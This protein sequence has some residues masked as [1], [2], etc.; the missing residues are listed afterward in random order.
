[1]SFSARVKQELEG[2]QK[3]K[4]GR[5]AFLRRAFLDTGSMSDPEKGYHLEFVCS[6][7]EEADLIVSALAAYEIRAK[8]VPRKKYQVVYIKESEDISTLLNVIGAHVS[9]MELENMRILKGVRNSVNRKVNCEAANITKAVNAA[10]KQVEDIEYI[11][12]H[13]GFDSLPDH[14]RQMAELRLEYPDAT[15][16]ELGEYLT[17]AVGK[18]GVNHRLRKLGE[19]AEKLKNGGFL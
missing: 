17:P 18:S 4:G 5:R 10:A 12:G 13:Y 8:I 9:L 1:M 3:G 11:K 19:L 7:G 6:D 15:L 2:A 14:L 16:K